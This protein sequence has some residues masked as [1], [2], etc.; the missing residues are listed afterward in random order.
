M[1][2]ISFGIIALNAQP[3][4]V[5]NLR[6][7]YPFAHQIIVVQG[8]TRAAAS[9]AT[10]EGHSTDDTL[11]ALS[12]F[13]SHEDPEG[14][15]QV[16][17]AKDEGF[18]DGFWP[19]KDQMSQAY[20]KRATGEWL[21]QVDSDEFYLTGDMQKVIGLL[22]GPE[23]VSGISFPFY[24]FWGGFDY[25]TTGKW[26]L[27]E[28]TSVPRVFRWGRGYT[29]QSHRPPTVLDETGKDISEQNWLSGREMRR[30]GIYMY[31][32]SYVLPKQAQQKV[33]YYSHVSWT[34]SFR[35]NARWYARSYQNL[36]SPLF[37]GERGW[38]ILQWLERYGGPHPQQIQHLRADLEAQKISEPLRPNADIEKLLN[39]PLYLLATKLLRLV[40][41]PYWRLRRSL[42]TK[43]RANT[44]GSA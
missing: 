1:I 44:G 40:M 5:H 3:F 24:E 41:L 29:Y 32:Y 6:A 18:A 28:F 11:Q 14:K 17:Q 42:R 7:L 31:H 27:Q 15:V 13:Q 37:L 23:P 8:A 20:A 12:R 33:G 4:L 16:L 36:R 34:D 43:K 21:W 39:S 38:P 35:H 9:L 30:L 2:K 26:Y 19:E 22:E 10:P 25:V